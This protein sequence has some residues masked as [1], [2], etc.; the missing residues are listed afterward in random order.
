M[1]LINSYARKLIVYR[2]E[3][4][5]RSN[6]LTQKQLLTYLQLLSIV[7]QYNGTLI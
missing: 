4:T 1:L 2:A 6:D 3:Y 5:S 7:P